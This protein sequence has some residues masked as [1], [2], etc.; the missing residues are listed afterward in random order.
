MAGNIARS[1]FDP[2]RDFSR[3]FPTDAS[4]RDVLDDVISARSGAWGDSGRHPLRLMTGRSVEEEF[5]RPASGGPMR[6]SHRVVP[7][8]RFY[9]RNAV[10]PCT[11]RM[12]RRTE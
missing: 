10:I 11:S 1:V 7:M 5:H 2:S 6:D 12:R 9:E 3:F 4:T 8:H